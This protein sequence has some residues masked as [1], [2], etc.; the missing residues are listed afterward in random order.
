MCGVLTENGFEINIRM[1]DNR[2]EILSP[3]THN[4]IV[5][6]ENILHTRFSR[7]PRIAS[8]LRNFGYVNEFGEGVKQVCRELESMGVPAPVYDC[9][10][11]LLRTVVMISSSSNV[12]TVVTKV[13]DSS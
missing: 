5:E 7:N 6:L 1:F 4:G 9:S 13:A 3:G 12:D 11:F 8:F 10:D 2:I